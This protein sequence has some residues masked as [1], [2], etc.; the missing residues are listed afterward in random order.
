MT[1]PPKN[2]ET[3]RGLLPVTGPAPVVLI[4]GSFPSVLSLVRGEYYG[5]PRNRFWAVM[6]EL[7]P[8]PA[9]L[10]YSERCLRLTQEGIALWDVVASCSRPGSADSRI[11]DP[12]PNDIAG[13]VRAHPPVRL[14]AMNGSTAG[15]LYHRLAEVPGIASVTLPST[16]PANAAVAFAEKVRRWEVLTTVQNGKE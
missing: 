10:P 1:G 4:L 9:T 8:V 5:N 13:F 6:E 11:R 3:S 14:V 16:S 12:V 15:R 2:S 7:F